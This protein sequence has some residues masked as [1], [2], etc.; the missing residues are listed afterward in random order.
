MLLVLICGALVSGAPAAAETT[1]DYVALGDSYSSGTGTRNYDPASGD[2][3]RSPAAYPELWVNSHDVATFVFDACSGATT[4]ELLASQLSNLSVETDLVTVSIGGND[5]GFSEVLGEC[6]VGGPQRCAAAIESAKE[7]IA[8]DLPARLDDVYAAI[9]QRA[10][11]ARLVVMGY[12]QLFELG[13]CF[14]SIDATHRERLNGVADQ[15]AAVTADRARSASADF[16]DVRAA[17]AGHRVCAAD[18][19]INGP[20][21]PVQESYHPDIH[22]HANAYLPALVAVTG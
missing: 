13:P 17:F 2:C 6:Q 4:A 16:V 20:S 1:V 11:N 22:G 10:N 3:L 12:P 9:Q 19:W 21:Y 18:E 14:N 15:L 7:F 8:E 5:A